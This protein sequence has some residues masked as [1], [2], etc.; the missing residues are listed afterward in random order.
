MDWEAYHHRLLQLLQR[1][2]DLVDRRVIEAVA[3]IPRHRF[4]P[5]L[6]LKEAYADKAMPTADGQT[7]SQPSL[8][9]WM[10][11]LLELSGS[12]RVLEIG[13]GSGYQTALLSRLAGEV[14]SIER[15][16]SL[17]H[18]AAKILAELGCRNVHL[19]IGDGYLGWPEAAPFDRLLLT[20]APPEMP[21]ALELQLREGGILIAPIGGQDEVQ[22]L[23]KGKRQ[24]DQ[25]YAEIL[26]EVRFV[27][28]VEGE[29]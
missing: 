23:L 21:R 12:E 25:V 5:N 18:G 19:R 3:A 16:A 6:S 24:G 17:S 26:S 4:V 14:W 1:Q 8:V 9:A 28:M 22:H 7:I 2:P 13:T 27:P 15:H 20:A 29:A 11:Q 10:T